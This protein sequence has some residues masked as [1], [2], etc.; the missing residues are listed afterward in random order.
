MTNKELFIKTYAPNDLQ[1]KNL[2][3]YAKLLKEYNEVMNLTGIDDFEEVYL[4]HFYDSLTIA[5]FIDKSNKLEIADL[6]SGAGFPGIILAIFF[7]NHQFYLIEPLQKRC[8]FL[9]VIIEKLSLK[10]VIIENKRMEEIN[11]QFDIITS[12][13]V[14]KLNILL[15]LAIPNLKINGLFIPLKGKNGMEEINQAQNALKEL[16]AKIQ[17]I[18][19]FNLPNENS[20]RINIVIEKIALTKDKYPRNFS[21]IKKKP[22]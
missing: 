18:D 15:E 13:A 12:R 16:N 22:L 4:K 8:K 10:N 14:A 2:D 20:K 6:G 19:E 17:D 5:K 21:Q 9:Q 11:H 7:P 1:L 3:L